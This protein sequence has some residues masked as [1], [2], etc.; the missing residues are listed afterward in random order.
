[1]AHYRY[2]FLSLG[3]EQVIQEIDLFG[4]YAKRVLSGPGQFNGSFV[5]D[6]TGKNNADLVAA[7][8]PGRTWLVMERNGVPI[9]WGI[10]WSRTYQS[11]AK[12]CQLY[13]W[14]F[15]AYPQ[16]QRVDADFVRTASSSTQVFCDLWTTMQLGAGR[17][18]NVNVPV[19]VGGPTLDLTVLAT[20]K[21][22]FSDPMTALASADDGFDWTIDLLKNLDGTYTKT[23]RVGYP[24]MGA[25]PNSP[26]LWTFEYPGNILNYY[27]SESM[28]DAGTNVFVTGAGEGSNAPE[29]QGTWQSMLDDGW[30][31]WDVDVTYK[32]ISDIIQLSNIASQELL[33][34]KPPMPTYTVVLKGD[35]NPVF[36][37]YNVGDAAQLVI[38]DARNPSPGGSQPGLTVPTI[39]AGWEL[40][41]S[42]A[43]S[44]EEVSLIFPGDVTNG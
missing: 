7:T 43:D 8:T 34:R 11:Q 23:L 14:G 27:E 9:W 31:R 38:T 30:P 22:Y 26:D 20:D 1:M 41:P 33:V 10:V 12:E 32:D 13:A 6:Q 35:Q 39:V 44:V 40:T 5:F 42:S 29:I 28:A 24:S 17:N 37:S 15:E 16:K 2:V 21:N 25:S 3:N 4:V 36:G 19:G 18:V